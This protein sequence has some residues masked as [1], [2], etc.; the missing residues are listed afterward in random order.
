MILRIFFAFI[1][2][3][4]FQVAVPDG[5]RMLVGRFCSSINCIIGNQM[6]FIRNIKVQNRSSS[7]SLY[8][9]PAPQIIT[10]VVL[11]KNLIH[12][13]LPC[14][15]ISSSCLAHPQADLLFP[16]GT[17]NAGKRSYLR[18]NHLIRMKTDAPVVV[19]WVKLMIKEI[20]KRGKLCTIQQ[21]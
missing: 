20:C 5:L 6:P 8:R 9:F 12:R 18:N 13:C 11:G 7:C 21:K 1:D 3:Q 2:R 17:E 14:V 10:G 16:A 19:F 4:A 15:L